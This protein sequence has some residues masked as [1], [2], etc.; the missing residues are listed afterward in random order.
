M[1]ISLLRFHWLRFIGAITALLLALIY[2]AEYE[3]LSLTGFGVMALIMT[4]GGIRIRRGTLPA[5]CDLCG[6]ASTMSAE[7]GAGFSNARLILSCPSCGRVVNRAENGIKP[8]K[9]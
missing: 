3:Y 2:L 1:R 7:Y 9:E 8:E 6:A 5:V 4:Y